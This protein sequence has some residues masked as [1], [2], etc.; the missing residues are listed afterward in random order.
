MPVE[1]CPNCGAVL[2][3]TDTHCME[4]GVEIAAAKREL[5]QKLKRERADRVSASQPSAVA[6]A[7]A[8][9]AEAGETSDKV[10]LKEF[11]KQ[12]AEH[13]VKERGAVIMTAVIALVIGVVVLMMGLSALSK[14]GGLD[15]VKSL[16]FNYL[17]GL[18]LGMFGDVTFMAVLTLL[19]GVSGLLCAIG[20]TRRFFSANRAVA[21]VRRSERPDIV[22][23]SGVTRAGL[24][25]A[26]V[27]CA[28]LGLILGIIF[29]FGRDQQTKELGGAMLRVSAAVIGLVVVNI[30]WNAVAGFTAS[31][32]P[33][34][35]VTNAAASGD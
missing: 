23:I 10:R 29:K 16:D 30:L 14:V 15:A 34:N 17:R 28:P 3:D 5:S 9:L 32:T 31:H 19:T 21:Q 2:Q 4:C 13:L 24:L 18:G 35:T 33:A 1:I 20:Q 25:L 27:V 22:G 7:G 6:G 11:D 12:L 8:G 26:S